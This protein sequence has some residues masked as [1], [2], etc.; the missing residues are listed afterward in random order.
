M[1]FKQALNRRKFVRNFGILSTTLLAHKGVASI[2]NLVSSRLKYEKVV[3][4]GTE[5]FRVVA[6]PSPTNSVWELQQSLD[7]GTSWTTITNATSIGGGKIQWDASS[8][9]KAE[10]F[11][12]KIVTATITVPNN[13]PYDI[14]LIEGQKLFDAME[15]LKLVIPS[16]TFTSQFHTGLGQFVTSING[17]SQGGG[18]KWILF[19]NGVS[20]TKG[21]S[22]LALNAGNHM[23]WRLI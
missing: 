17:T 12:A 7:A 8:I 16:F 4:N 18:L 20:S 1:I 19:V 13:T 23:E 2:T 22:Q 5:I 10:F 11:R 3:V 15:S 6:T 14:P 9:K 21:S